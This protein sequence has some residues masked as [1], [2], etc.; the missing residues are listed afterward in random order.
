MAVMRKPPAQ[1]ELI[2][3]I[4]Q[5]WEQQR[6]LWL[7]NRVQCHRPTEWQ[8]QTLPV[9]LAEVSAEPDLCHDQLNASCLLQ[10]DRCPGLASRRCGRGFHLRSAFVAGMCSKCQDLCSRPVES[11]RVHGFA[12]YV[13]SSLRQHRACQPILAHV[14]AR[15]LVR[16]CV[17]PRS[18]S[19]LGMGQRTFSSPRYPS[20]A[21]AQELTCCGRVEPGPHE[22]PNLGPI[23]PVT[24][25]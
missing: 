15:V 2:A 5:V 7:A 14:T 16:V 3:Q 13:F 23:T 8:R 22:C 4:A 20:T 10:P 17:G 12:H 6:L 24:S 9:L 19:C 25:V 11:V 21:A 18:A 1:L